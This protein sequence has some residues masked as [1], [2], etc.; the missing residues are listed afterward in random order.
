MSQTRAN[1]AA[2]TIRP[3]NPEQQEQ[4]VRA[5][6]KHWNKGATYEEYLGVYNRERKEAIWAKDHA[7]ITWALVKTDDPEGQLYAG[8]ETYRRRGFVKR[9]GSDE[10]EEGAVYVIASVVTPSEHLRNGYATRLLSLLHHVLGPAE[11]LPPVPESWGT[12]SIAIP[13]QLSSNI[14]RALGSI[15][16]SDVGS[17]FYSRCSIGGTRPGWVVEDSMCSEIV[18][19][20]LPPEGPPDDSV[21]L[22]YQDDL[23]SISETLSAEAKAKLEGADTSKRSL[24]IQDPA[25]TGTLSFVPVRG[26]WPKAPTHDPLPVGLR[27]RSPSG[28]AKDDTIVLFATS[29][30][31]IEGSRFLVTYVSNLAP[32]Q[33]PVVLSAI[34]KLAT[35]A[36]HGLGWVWDLGLESELVQAWKALPGREV[37]SGRRQEIDGHLL[38][39]AWYGA[40]EEEGK[41][42]EGQMWSWA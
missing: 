39:V 42:I 36:G 7:L 2:Y 25:S 24:F 33:L 18:W 34:D 17:T 23:L 14:P 38:G 16:W 41:M 20:I 5:G 30:I 21:E 3:A 10:I 26:T 27:I 1:L 40:E 13:P 19:K 8:C 4:H 32:A 31:A 29:N 35:E 22:L 9:K 28:D 12:S 37:Q 11:S 15:L 6:F